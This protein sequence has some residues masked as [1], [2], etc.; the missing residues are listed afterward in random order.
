MCRYIGGYGGLPNIEYI[1]NDEDTCIFIQVGP[2]YGLF[3][4]WKVGTGP[5]ADVACFGEACGKGFSTIL[6][7]ISQNGDKLNGKY[8]RCDCD[9]SLSFFF[10]LLFL[11]LVC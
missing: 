9:T 3:R 4:L 11:V 5:S 10:V 7:I 1:V 2:Q 8:V 6:S